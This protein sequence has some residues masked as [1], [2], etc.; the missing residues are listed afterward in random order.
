MPIPKRMQRG[1]EQQ[2]FLLLSWKSNNLLGS[3]KESTQTIILYYESTNFAK[4]E[5]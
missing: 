1:L 3:K 5:E 2:L 4:L